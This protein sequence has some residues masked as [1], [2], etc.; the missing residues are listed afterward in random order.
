M[1]FRPPGYSFAL[2]FLLGSGGSVIAQP[3]G[4]GLPLLTRAEQ[5][6][7]LPPTES[8][9]SYP[10]H[11]EGVVTYIDP[12]NPIVSIIIIQDWTGGI[13]VAPRANQSWPQV[14]EKVIVEGV[15]KPGISQAYVVN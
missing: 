8:E 13:T 9:R 15:T 2:V 3:N 1:P 4:P 5:I 11:I 12:T 6:R 14:G 10:V 7:K